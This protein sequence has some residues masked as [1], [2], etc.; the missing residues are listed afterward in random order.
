MDS[1]TVKE[2]IAEAKKNERKAR[3]EWM[4]HDNSDDM[5]E[6]EMWSAAVGWLTGKLP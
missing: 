4:K 5:H 1:K 3:S 2:L 6:M